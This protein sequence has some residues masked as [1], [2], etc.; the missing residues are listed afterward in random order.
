MIRPIS[1][2]AASREGF[3]SPQKGIMSRWQW[4]SI[5]I[6]LPHQCADRCAYPL[7]G[8]CFALGFFG[9]LPDAGV[10]GAEAM[11]LGARREFAPGRV[12]PLLLGE[13]FGNPELLPD[14]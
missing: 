7:S 10:D 1:D 9:G 11:G 8:L 12:G 3:S 13:R 5:K 14:L 2:R 6:G 4:E